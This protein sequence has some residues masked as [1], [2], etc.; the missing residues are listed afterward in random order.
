MDLLQQGGEA[1]GHPVHSWGF[2][3]IF[4]ADAILYALTYSKE[5]LSYTK[6]AALNQFLDEGRTRSIQ[7]NVWRPLQA[8]KLMHEKFYWI[9]INVQ[10]TIEG[11]NK[12]LNYEASSDEMMRVYLP[13]GKTEREQRGWGAGRDPRA[14]RLCV[15]SPLVPCGISRIWVQYILKRLGEAVLVCFGISVI[16]FCCC[17]WLAIPF[18]SCSLSRRKPKTPRSCGKA[19]DSTSPS[20]SSTAS[21]SRI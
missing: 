3:S 4:D 13:P 11:V 21:S 2:N 7:R 19:W 5:P 10:Y 20:M 8:Q 15:F 17:T 1:G 6:D 12:K 18:N 16:T 14:D 9:P